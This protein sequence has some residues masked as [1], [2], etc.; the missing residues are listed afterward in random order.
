M[1]RIISAWA[2]N[3]FLALSHPQFRWLFGGTI[4]STL[5]YMMMFVA[6]SIVAHRLSGTN[7]AVGIISL[8]I[9]FSMFFGGPF[10]G[11][12]AD[13]VNRKWLIVCGQGAGASL[14]ALTGAL[15]L[16]DLMTLPIFFVLMLLLGGTFVIMG[17]ARNAF[18]GDIVGPK[19]L[20]NAITL[21]QLAHT[22]GQPFSPYIATVLIAG[23]AG[24]GGTYVTMG[25]LVFIGVLTV[26]FLPSRGK[27]PSGE[28][29][30]VIGDIADGA[31]YV[32]RKPMLRLMLSLF[33]AT[34]VLGFV[35][36]IL[37]PQYLV[38]HMGRP[39]TDLGQL[40]LVNGL[41]A[42]AVALVVAG[43]S[44]SRWAWPAI[45]SMIVVMGFGYVM[46]AVAGSYGETL[47]AM[48]L[49]GPGLQGP[50]MLLQARI[51]MQTEPAYYGRVMA[52]TMMSWGVQMLL[53]FPTGVAADVLG[54]R[55]VMAGLGILSFAVAGGAFFWWIAVRGHEPGGE[56]A[57][58]AIAA[59]RDLRGAAH[60][61]PVAQ[62]AGPIPRFEGILPVALM[63]AQKRNA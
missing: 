2:S 55:E 50:V 20:P 30:S 59:G 8:A 27:P 32:Y 34:V 44:T 49:L 11:V 60:P 46:L 3:T 4:F 18:T 47:V 36:R 62:A 24:T 21:S 19:L 5:A 13:R 9:G 1:N 23:V 16:L 54:E 35:F 22:F 57:A 53:G 41:A 63:T 43:L 28:P 33:V 40:M 12:L 17:P 6:M 42:A 29:R 15:L 26:V 56:A 58:D 10:G 38:E 48:A 51:M 7:T 25:A 37:M 52:F 14:L 61:R 39:D 31:R 45:L